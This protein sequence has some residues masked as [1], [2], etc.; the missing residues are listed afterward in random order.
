M[1]EE[2]NTAVAEAK[3]APP[4]GEGTNPD[5]I[6]EISKLLEP[7]A[8]AKPEP[9]VEAKTEPEA[10]VK[11]E[12]EPEP[13]PEA[14]AEPEKKSRSADDF[15]L[16]KSQR[17]SAKSEL[18][19]LRA[20]V[21]DLKKK[22]ESVD[23]DS[24]RAERDD[25]SKRLRAASIERHPEF[26]KFFTGKLNGVISR[27]KAT[28]GE[29]GERMEQILKMDSSAYRD[30]QMEELFSELPASKQATLGALI[31][32]ADEVKAERQAQLADADSTYEQ[33]MASQSE[34]REELL[35]KS[36]K[37]FD[38]VA[39]RATALE[40]YQKREGDDEW[41]AEVDARLELAR[42]GFLG[43]SDE[44]ELAML[45]LWGAAGEKYR[46]LLAT[47]IELNRR[48]QKQLDGVQGST[49]S[50]A[51]TDGKKADT[52]ELGF[53]EEVMQKMGG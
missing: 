26:E 41:N 10:E 46:E 14:K 49:P 20:E 1:S 36:R 51:A 25:L 42:N 31:A 39:D 3:T 28:A 11:P 24:L 21:A 4:L 9:E 19:H 45:S 29:H 50:V 23:L 33:L 34:Q 52:K 47:Q 40:V 12:P 44:N 37:T 15:K 38:E 35:A 6:S 13:E 7:E 48:L 8:E 5:L 22:A 2:T 18:E 17:D 27:A 53:V 16:L 43:Q 30:A 32:Q